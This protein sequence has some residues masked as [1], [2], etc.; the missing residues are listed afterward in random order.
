MSFEWRYFVRP[1]GSFWRTPNI[2]GHLDSVTDEEFAGMDGVVGGR[3]E[4]EIPVPCS[5]C[6]RKL[7]L[8]WR[9]PAPG[10]LLELCEGCDSGRPAASDLIRWIGDPARRST[11]LPLLFEMWETE[12]MESMGWVFVPA[13]DDPHAQN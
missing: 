12:T 13:E 8:H 9:A 10:V 11:D 3:R 4:K 6:T 7:L 1:D 5:R 2:D